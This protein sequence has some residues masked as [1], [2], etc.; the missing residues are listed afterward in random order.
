MIEHTSLSNIIC[1]Q[2]LLNGC[3][4]LDMFTSRIERLA[5]KIAQCEQDKPNKYLREWQSYKGVSLTPS[6][7]G[8]KFKGDVFEI[9]CEVLIK[10]SPI[11]DRIGIGDY[12]PY[13]PGSPLPSWAIHDPKDDVGV[14]GY[15][16]S[17]DGTP[18][19]VQCKYRIWDW[20]LSQ[21]DHLDN[22]R[23]SSMVHF[24][25]AP[26]AVGKMLIITTGKELSWHTAQ[27]Q[28]M[29]KIRCISRDASFGCLWGSKQ[30]V[31]KFFSLKTMVDENLI[32]WNMFRKEIGL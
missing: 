10:L 31:D 18:A 24:G 7:A 15:G 27:E 17:R 3:N 8:N 25:I 13:N 2:D 32:F 28:F 23:V 12:H 16:L 21:R 14:D 1:W 9:F 6:D 11:D 19:T 29:G 26:E 30:T 5:K 4:G 20:E 22:F